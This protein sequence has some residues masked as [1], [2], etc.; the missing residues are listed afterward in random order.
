MT[1][2]LGAWAAEELGRRVPHGARQEGTVIDVEI[3][4]D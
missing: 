2:Q 1:R 3:L 4:D